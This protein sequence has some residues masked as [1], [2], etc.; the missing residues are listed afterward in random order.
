MPQVNP[1]ERANLEGKAL[2][3][4]TGGKG[5]RATAKELGVSEKAVRNFRDKM[6]KGGEKDDFAALKGRLRL[7]LTQE[8]ALSELSKQMKQYTDNYDRAILE[9]EKAALLWSRNRIDLLEKMLRVTGIYD[10]AANTNPEPIEITI[11]KECPKCR[12]RVS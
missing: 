9:D 2:A 3:L 11:V 1:V 8:N 10:R 5:I 7:D 4:L 12:E 6:R